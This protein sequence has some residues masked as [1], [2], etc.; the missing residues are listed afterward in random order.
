MKSIALI[1]PTSDF[2]MYNIIKMP[3]LGLLMLGTL[4]KKKG[5]EVRVFSER[6]RRIYDEKTLWIN[7]DVLD[8]D[9]VGISIMTA[10]AMR[11]YRIADSLKQRNPR[12]HIL[13]GGIHATFQP[14]EALQHGDAVITGEGENI[15]IEAVESKD[16]GCIFTGVP[17]DNLD[18]LP[19]TDMDLTKRSYL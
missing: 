7:P 2:S 11:G 1:E 12:Q 17:I 15:I 19:P 18:I 6:V 8:S 14:Y 9:V 10:T 5:Y 13:F 3:L 4:L 16:N